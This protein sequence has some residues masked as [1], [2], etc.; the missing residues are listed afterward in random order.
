MDRHEPARRREY[1]GTVPVSAVIKRWDE[2]A[3]PA[4]SNGTGAARTV[5]IRGGAIAGALRGSSAL[6][7]LPPDGR[8]RSLALQKPG[9]AQAGRGYDMN[10]GGYL[11]EVRA[12][13][14]TGQA[15]EHSYR[16]ALAACSNRS[17]PR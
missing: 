11:D 5:P 8:C 12:K 14:A 10:I 9:A 2:P 13:Y 4:V 15:T 17:I 1:G 16:P 7:L 3:A 6:P